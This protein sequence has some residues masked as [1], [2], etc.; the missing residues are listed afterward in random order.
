MKIL[1]GIVIVLLGLSASSCD[2]KKEFRT[3]D[4]PLEYLSIQSSLIIDPVLKEGTL[5]LGLITFSDEAPEEL[6]NTEFSNRPSRL[7]PSDK[8]SAETDL[9]RH[10][11]RWTGALSGYLSRID[12]QEPNPF[13][14]P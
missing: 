13:S 2:E 4:Y 5:G 11:V 8:F 14:H 3:A 6:W 10:S 9:D 7:S 1:R 12:Y